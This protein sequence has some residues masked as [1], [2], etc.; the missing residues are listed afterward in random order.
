MAFKRR[1]GSVQL[2]IDGISRDDDHYDGLRAGVITYDKDDNYQVSYLEL[3]MRSDHLG[4]VI[5]RKPRRQAADTPLPYDADFVV[6]AP[7]EATA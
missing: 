2:L 1:W 7:K 5:S 3:G 4:E 6:S